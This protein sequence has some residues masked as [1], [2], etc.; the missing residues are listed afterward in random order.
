MKRFT[1][2]CSFLAL[3][4]AC[5]TDPKASAQRYVTNG[6]KYFQNGKLKQAS[7][8]Y[9]RALQKD[10]RNAEAWYQLGLA[11][12]SENNL[13]EARRNFQRCSALLELPA[14][15]PASPLPPK[16]SAPNAP[17]PKA[18]EAAPALDEPIMSPLVPH[19]PMWVDSVSQLGQI[20]FVAHNVYPKNQEFSRELKDASDKLLKDDPKSFDGLRL[21]GFYA[22]TLFVEASNDRSEKGLKNQ[23]KARAEVIARFRAA[24]AV[25][26]YQP[27]VVNM[28]TQFLIAANQAAEGEQLA[29]ELIEKQKTNQQVYDILY[30]RYLVTNRPQEAEQL[31]KKKI[32]YNP[33]RPEYVSQLA[34]FYFL[35]HRQTEMLSTISQVTADKK[36]FP[37]GRL[38]AG[39]FYYAIRA[40]DE[41][42]QQYR[43]GL[44]E[45]P[46]ERST[47]QKKLVEAL[48]ISGK[49]DEAAK[50]VGELVKEHPKD[51]ETIAMHASV[52]LER[53]DPKQA[54]AIIA[55]LKPV[56]TA[57]PAA[58]RDRL[59]VL[60]YNL[61]RAYALKNDSASS[62]QA[63]RHFQDTL[64]AKDNYIPAKL[65]L[66]QL[67]LNRGEN[68][69]AVQH[70]N[71]ILAIDKNN[72]TAKLVRAIARL[73][74]KD[75]DLGAKELAVM[76]REYPA[77]TDVRFQIGRL[78]FAQGRFKEAEADFERLFKANDPRALGGLI[79]CKV[80]QGQ[81][82]EAIRLVQGQ[83]T[84]TPDN[85]IYRVTLASLE[86]NA[87]KY[88]D[89]IR[90]FQLAIDKNPQ[91][92]DLPA[93]YIRLGEA[94]RKAGDLNGS[95]ACFRKARELSP[96]DAG[97]LLQLALLFDT[98][99]R[100]DEARK[101]YEDVLKMQ[102]D[103][104]VAL[105]NVAYA[106]ADEGV[107]LDNALSL[108]E[109][110]R[111]KRPDDPDVLDTVSLI[112]LKKNS[113]DEGLRLLRELVTRKPNNPTYR[114]HLALALYQKG[115]R[116]EAK[117]E[118]QT[119]MRFNP[120]ARDQQRIRELMAKIG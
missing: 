53:A 11:N 88:P 118:L 77:S 93:I 103:N 115:N 100:S 37:H 65:A 105:N 2:L 120:S 29:R 75:Y 110:A 95:I 112:F 70:A 59:A 57:T 102:P 10:P 79:E 56:L 66:A 107:D 14:P 21:S 36:K 41:A 71:E 58:Q 97:P 68:P 76:E 40:Y 3:F 119:A 92:T 98:N 27:D 114:V 25:K 84:K 64:L 35:T 16:T 44:T 106:K 17:A 72:L 26:P 6:K 23:E 22:T 7:I 30:T 50:V 51:P 38:L 13:G 61:A 113:T 5:N 74:M 63:K 47:Y 62:E 116:P 54:D 99:G 45:D 78:N 42:V 117:R 101:I 24:N 81:T 52:L 28:L 19:D 73:N 49:H 33:Q 20:D 9:R 108:A 1:L 67:E 87:E 69:Q 32:A 34:F 90:D 60:H 86:F 43:Q 80:A 91:S 96:K 104:A 8:M 94:K 111:N 85:L 55:E 109:R 31:L 4:A 15:K 39:D 83:L 82:D 46:K 12:L 18:A 89:S 48:T